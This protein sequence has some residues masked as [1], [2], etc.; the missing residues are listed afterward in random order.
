M[1]FNGNFEDEEWAEGEP[2]VSKLVFIGKNLDHA[3]LQREFLAC[4]STPEA[5]EKRLKAL[6][7]AIG[8]KVKCNLGSS[9]GAG[10]V[11][12]LMYREDT[13]PPGMVAPYQVEL[14]SGDVIFAP[15]DDDSVVRK[16]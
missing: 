9:W 7:F 12:A 14:D 15:S 8:D 6:R 4:L 16:A 13:M 2:R 3:E 1:I 5:R 10:K 11:V